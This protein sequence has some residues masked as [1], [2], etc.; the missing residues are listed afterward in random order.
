MYLT[1]FICPGLSFGA[2]ESSFVNKV[3]HDLGYLEELNE[4]H[5]LVACKPLP[6]SPNQIVV[7]IARRQAGTEIN[8]SETMGDYSLDISLVDKETGRT[9]VHKFIKQRFIWDGT[10]FDGIEIDTAKYRVSPS[11]RAFGIRAKY[12]SGTRFAS[13]ET[14]SLFLVKD[15]EIREVLTDADMEIEFHT[16]YPECSPN[17]SRVATRTLAIASEETNGF[18]NLLVTEVLVDSQREEDE[19]GACTQKVKNKKV[20]KYML[21]FDGTKYVVPDDMKYFECRVC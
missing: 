10:S 7:A 11:L 21:R 5:H 16:N 13:N 20:K 3:R 4:N 8:D 6:N 1:I 15:N 2:C 19:V 18:Y 12:H 9:V 17:E 14:L